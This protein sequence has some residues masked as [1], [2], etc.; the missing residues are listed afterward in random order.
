MAAMQLK[1]EEA[2]EFMR[3]FDL[4]DDK[5]MLGSKKEK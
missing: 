5:G 1:G 2:E 4:T 3:D